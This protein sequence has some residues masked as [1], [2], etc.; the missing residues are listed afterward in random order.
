MNSRLTAIGQATSVIMATCLAGVLAKHSLGDVPAFTFVWLQIGIGCG[1]LTLYTFVVRRERIPTGLGCQV[2]AYV[3]WLGIANFAIVRVLFM[4]SLER[5]PAT[6][7]TYL[8]NFVGVVT[9][10][11]SIFLLRE[12]PSLFQ[13]GGALVALSGLWVFFPELPP[14]DQQ[15]G[16]LYVSIAVLALASTNNIAR[17]LALV[18]RNQLSNNVV[19]TLAALIGGLPVVGYGLWTDGAPALPGWKHWGI[20]ALNGLVAISVGLTVW[21]FILRTLRSYEASILAATSVIFT[22]LFALPILGE[23]LA[24]HQIVGIVLMLAGVVLAQIRRGSYE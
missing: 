19:S 18:T 16:L 13:V 14:P 9:M 21:N 20:I 3:V 24:G 8:V 2:W 4:L 1:L 11:M 5:L 12:R 7:H 22:A 23:R 10:V 17:K 6:T 15:I